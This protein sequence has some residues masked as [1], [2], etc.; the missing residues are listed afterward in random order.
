MATDTSLEAYRSLEPDVLR[1]LRGKVFARIAS[2]PCTSEEA[3]TALCLSS[4][5]V[6]P[7]IWELRKMGLVR[8]SGLRRKT[9]SGRNA[10][11]YEAT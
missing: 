5:T 7:R 9:R 2:D 8:D 4:N 6:V 11:V 3:E 1:T 10:R